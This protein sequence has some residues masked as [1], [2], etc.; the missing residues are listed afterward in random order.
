MFTAFFLGFML[1]ILVAALTVCLV[2]WFVRRSNNIME[3]RQ[4]KLKDDINRYILKEILYGDYSFGDIYFILDINKI[5]LGNPSYIMAIFEIMDFDEDGEANQTKKQSVID[6]LTEY[7]TQN[8]KDKFAFVLDI[9]RSFAVLLTDVQDINVDFILSDAVTVLENSLSTTA[10]SGK[11]EVFDDISYIKFAYDEATDALAFRPFSYDSPVIAGDE[12]LAVSIDYNSSGETKLI[13]AVVGND[14]S[15]SLE[16]INDIFKLNSGDD[17]SIAS[18][19][20]LSLEIVSSIVQAKVKVNGDIDYRYL[21][22][23]YHDILISYSVDT[24]K[25]LINEFIISV[26]ADSGAKTTKRSAEKYQ[27]IAKYIEDNFTNHMLNVNMIS[28]AFGM[29]RTYLS[30][31]F[32][33]KTG[34]GIAEYIVK[35]RLEKS[36]S[37]LKS[38]SSV[39]DAAEGSGF[40]ST[41]VFSRAFK[42]YEGTTPGKYKSMFNIEDN[43]P[44]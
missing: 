38:G 27:S 6:S 28:Y 35:L 12:E 5:E 42:K 41:V 16:L 18:F 19:R 29:N 8:L 34:I 43:N 25:K 44:G 32:K 30:D 7:F 15:L 40:S 10:V 13:N 39:A 9:K 14:R 26:C 11:S 4:I 1:C 17:T 21:Y 31:I 33:K 3:S 37:M 24:L 20:I 2:M 36:K 23:L 22:R